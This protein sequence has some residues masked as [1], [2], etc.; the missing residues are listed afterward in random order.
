M[1]I[2][3][4]SGLLMPADVP[5]DKAPAKYTKGYRDL[6]VR[7]R[8]RSHLENFIRERMEP[9]GLDYSEIE[10][11]PNKDYDFRFYTRRSD[12]GIAIVD[13]IMAI[14]YKKFKPTA[15]ARDAKGKMLYVDGKEYHTLLN[16]IWAKVSVLGNP[17]G[18]D[19]GTTGGVTR[20]GYKYSDGK[21]YT[22]TSFGYPAYKKGDENPSYTPP[23]AA[24]LAGA[25]IRNP[26]KVL[27]QYQEDEARFGDRGEDYADLPITS[28]L[29]EHWFD[30]EDYD[31]DVLPSAEHAAMALVPEEEVN[32]RP[33]P[34]NQFKTAKQIITI[35]KFVPF[36]K[37]DDVFD[38]VEIEYLLTQSHEFAIDTSTGEIKATDRPEPEPEDEQ[39]YVQPKGV[40][41]KMVD[42]TIEVAVDKS[43]KQTSPSKEIVKQ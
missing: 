6:Q 29:G 3:N 30:D 10:A 32:R 21:G 31:R 2:F 5:M 27:E 28:I 22:P 25:G 33:E 9:L 16:G 11:T 1:W 18:G 12:F 20:R 26:D 4:P 14:D 7:A 13:E 15:E 35:A 39:A 38:E 42:K 36:E 19:W 17:Y 34:S 23:T 40:I 24:S 8:V 37:W 43:I 41:E